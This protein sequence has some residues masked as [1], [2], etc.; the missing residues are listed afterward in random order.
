MAGLKIHLQR[1]DE[2]L[3]A[4]ADIEA[5]CGA[6]VARAVFALYAD[7]DFPDVAHINSVAVCSKCY[8]IRGAGKYIYALAQGEEAIH[9]N[10]D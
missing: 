4:G 2:P 5:L 3:T 7:T 8:A 9:A 10:T 1:V 6:V